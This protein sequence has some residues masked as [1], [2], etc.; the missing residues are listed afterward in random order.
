MFSYER[1]KDRPTLFLAMTGL[2]QEE[3]AHLLPVFQEAWDA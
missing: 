3:F 1:V 2:S